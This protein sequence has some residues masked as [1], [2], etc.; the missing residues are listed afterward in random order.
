MR[1]LQA[2]GMGGKDLQTVDEV[3]KALKEMGKEGAYRD[4]QGIQQLMQTSL[5]K[6]KKFEFDMRKKLDTTNDQLFLSGAE[7]VPSNFKSLVDEYTR[8]LGKSGAAPPKA[9]T[10]PGTGGTTPPPAKPG[11]GG[12]G[13]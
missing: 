2:A 6:L 4:P 3:A 10:K 9:A 11:R 8:Q 13:K 1:A 5:E 7:E 12:G